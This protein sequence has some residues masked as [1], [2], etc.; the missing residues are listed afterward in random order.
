MDTDDLSKA[1][2][3]GII[4]EC[5]KYNHDLTLQFGILA[6]NCKDDDDYLNKAEAVIKDWLSDDDFEIIADDIF[7]GASVDF[8]AF[9]AILEKLLTNINQIRK[10][11]MNEREYEQ[12]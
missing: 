8:D 11:P 7:F 9:K 10:T 6:S 1:T 2:Y 12:W 5:E 3:N 4:L